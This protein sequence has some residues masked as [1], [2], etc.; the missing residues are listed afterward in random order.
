MKEKDP[1]IP[2]LRRIREMWKELQK[3]E[4]NSPEYERLVEQIRVL[5][6]EYKALVNAPKKP[7]KSK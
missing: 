1:A 3:T 6:T 2:R 4:E 7:E 5:A